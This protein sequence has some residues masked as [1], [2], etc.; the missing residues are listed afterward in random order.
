MFDWNDVRHLLAVADH[1]S[2]IAAG[3]ALRVSQSTVQRRLAA[4][5]RATGV[6]LAIRDVGGY[7]LT[8]AGLALLEDARRAGVAMDAFATRA[9]KLADEER[10]VLRLTCPEPIVPRLMPLLNRFETE[11]GFAV[12]IVT[13]DRYVDLSAGEADV[14]FRSGDTDA[15]LIGMTVAKSSWAVYAAR[16]YA[17]GH[18]HMPAM[19]AELADHPLVSLETGA[20]RHRLPEWLA[21]VAPQARIAARATSVL[22]L[23]QA[24]RS[25][26]G[27]APLP[28]NV[29]DADTELMRL[30]GPVAELER[31]WRLLTTRALRKAPRVDA[32]FGYVSRVNAELRAAL[33]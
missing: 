8:E 3:N 31:S 28:A 24:V 17:A 23:I 4:L 32:F 12:E 10:R 19:P 11:S 6:T 15:D 30:F 25:G 2:T 33:G 26:I 13:S 1:G 7:R 14:A 18:A 5:Q 20:A 29:A 21:A 9:A 27:I 22:G 16:A